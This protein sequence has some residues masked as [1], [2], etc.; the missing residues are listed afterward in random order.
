MSIIPSNQPLTTHLY[1]HTRQ[2]SSDSSMRIEALSLPSDE[3]VAGLRARLGI[4]RSSR[5]LLTCHRGSGEGKGTCGVVLCRL[6]Y[7]LTLSPYHPTDTP[8]AALAVP[9]NHHHQQQPQPQQ[10]HQARPGTAREGDEEENDD[11]ES[12][13]AEQEEEE[14]RFPGL[15]TIEGLP[16]DADAAAVRGFVCVYVSCID[17]SNVCISI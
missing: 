12:T 17:L 4:P 1:T 3:T 7:L 8:A 5:L 2:G 11:E 14:P 9:S 6:D 15:L 13:V 10:P 16:L